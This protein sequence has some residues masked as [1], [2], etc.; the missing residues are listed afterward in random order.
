[1]NEEKQ[2]TRD[3]S[4]TIKGT[5][6]E[7]APRVSGIRRFARVLFARRVVIL[8][9]VVIIILLLTAVFAPFLAPYD[10]YKQNL[11][12]ILSKPN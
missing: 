9:L 3:M 6:N 11:G 5:I 4:G 12:N 1:M 10:P 7:T 8:G 2:M